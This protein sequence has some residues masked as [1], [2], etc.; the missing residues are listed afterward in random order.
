M[1]NLLKDIALA[2]IEPAADTAPVGYVCAPA[3]KTQ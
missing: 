3:V 2:D 1:D